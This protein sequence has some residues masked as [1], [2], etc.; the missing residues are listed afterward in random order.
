MY[1]YN[2]YIYNVYIYIL[3]VNW[4]V[5]VGAFTCADFWSWGVVSLFSKI[6]QL[7]MSPS[8]LTKSAKGVHCQKKILQFWSLDRVFSSLGPGRLHVKMPYPSISDVIS[9]TT[10][11]DRRRIETLFPII[12]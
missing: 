9:M 2:V 1:I 7:G 12:R 5:G 3:Y 11:P 6:Y 10:R 8:V 4:I